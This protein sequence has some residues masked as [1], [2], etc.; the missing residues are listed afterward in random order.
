M[1]SRTG[2]ALL[3][4]GRD[5]LRVLSIGT[6]LLWVPHLLPLIESPP[7]TTVADITSPISSKTGADRVHRLFG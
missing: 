2:A 7:T 6:S 4:V 1:A 3:F 5:G